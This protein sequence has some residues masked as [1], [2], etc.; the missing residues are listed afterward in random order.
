VAKISDEARR[1]DAV[2]EFG[3]GFEI[4]ERKFWSGVETRIEMQEQI[5]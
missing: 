3:F 5:A 1:R 4:G 2:L